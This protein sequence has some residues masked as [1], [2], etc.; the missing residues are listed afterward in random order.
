MKRRHFLQFGG[1]L[2]ASLG[3]SQV[4]FFQQANRYGKVLAQ[5]TPRKLA[6]LVGINNYTDG[7]RPL[8]GCLM[9]VEMQREL[10]IHRFGF[11]PQD[12]LVVTDSQATR[13]G[14]ITAFENHLIKQAKP[15]DVAVFH[16][17]GHGSRVVDPAPINGKNLNG[18][19]V[20]IDTVTPDKNVVKDIMGKTL[21]LLMSAVQTENLTVVLDSCFSGGA[22]RG[23]LVVRSARFERE[24]ENIKVDKAELEYQ[25]KLLSQLNFSPDKFQ[26]LRAKGIAKGVSLTS[27]KDNQLATDAC[28]D[29]F[30]A[31]AFTYLLTRYLW[32]Q[33]RNQAISTT[34]V[35]LALRTQDIAQ[36]SGNLQVPE[37]EVKPGSDYGNKLVYFS[38]Q[39]KRSAEGVIRKVSGNQVEFWLGGI[40]S[41]SLEGFQQGSI[42]NLI[43]N[44][45]KEI[46]QIEQI[47]RVGLVGYGKVIKNPNAA[48]PGVL[49]RERVR[50]IPTDLSLK[51][52]LDESLGAEKSLAEK[53][54]KAISRMEVVGVN[55]TDVV[56]YILG[57]VRENNSRE[58]QQLSIPNPPPV[59]AIG[60]FTSGRKPVYNTFGIPEESTQAAIQQRL[61]SKFKSLLAGRI[62]QTLVTGDSS[63]LKV[64]TTIQAVN[65]RSTANVVSS[66][67]N[68]ESQ[69]AP[70][71]SIQNTNFKPG[72]AMQI[73][74]QNNENQNLFIGVVLIDSSG[75]LLVLFPRDWDKPEDAALL[76]AGK[77]ITIP[78][79]EDNFKILL[80]GPSGTLEVLV[81][82]SVS[83]VRNALKGLQ[84]IARSRNTAK[85]SPLGISEDEPDKVMG[86]LLID[87]DEMSRAGVQLVSTIRGVDTTKIAVLSSLVEVVE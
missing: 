7:V 27:A 9:D 16:Y 44:Q 37:Y 59:G 29:G 55:Q 60:L 17:S 87:F 75:E 13:Q 42:F 39:T 1:S 2:L 69:Q 73:N 6:L 86:D 25:Q 18:T 76:G 74:I 4:E 52:G 45:G 72:T 62:L 33:N 14:I 63:T 5:S 77:I 65:S 80:Q 34:F 48:K 43:D 32:Q 41:Q 40:A 8:R 21:F 19:M 54:I 30:N 49:L 68:Q 81:L 78:R 36:T 24:T 57:R 84:N 3:I 79:T 70:I 26:E 28:F 53:E 51:I 10:L 82:A 31:G 11:Q 66:R 83:P 20:P 22:D 50:G 56:H 64:T 12:I 58:F 67:G 15:G 35:N 38:E 23:N 46:G 61:K 71:N 85:G 47:S